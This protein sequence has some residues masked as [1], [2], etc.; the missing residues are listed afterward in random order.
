MDRR[1]LLRLMAA[2]ST[3]SFLPRSAEAVVRLGRA[4]HRA[5]SPV[6]RAMTPQTGRLVSTLADLILPRTETP[7]ATDVG[8]PQFIDGLLADWFPD[9][10]RRQF[11]DG[12]DDLN[13]RA[14]SRYRASFVDLDQDTQVAMLATLDGAE[15]SPASAEAAFSRLK[16]LTVYGY[17]T[18]ETV[19]RDVLQDPII[20][21][22]FEGCAPWQ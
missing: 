21:G 4:A 19:A 6:L 7:G 10:E 15:G 14:G 18:S 11:L 1:D 9:D 3:L 13:R 2:A 20:P 8:I 5:A 17:F 12:L 16:S 22:R